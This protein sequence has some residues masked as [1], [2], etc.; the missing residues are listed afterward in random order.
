MT[1]TTIA[2]IARL[3]HFMIWTGAISF[4]LLIATDTPNWWGA[5]FFVSVFFLF[6]AAMSTFVKL[7]SGLLLAAAR[8]KSLNH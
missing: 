8:R 1:I 5:M 2:V 4:M 3:C 6:A 7:V